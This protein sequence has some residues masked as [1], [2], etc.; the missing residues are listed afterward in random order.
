[1][2]LFVPT[3]ATNPGCC[4]R[5]KKGGRDTERES[6]GGAL[7]TSRPYT[8]PVFPE[9]LL[10]K[11]LSRLSPWQSQGLVTLSLLF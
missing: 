9:N 3:T 5:R 10:Q 11:H 2:S 8:Q 1:M 4:M 7:P 6:E